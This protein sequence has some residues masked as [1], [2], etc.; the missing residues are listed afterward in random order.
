M[1]EANDYGY[2]CLLLK[3]GTCATDYQNYL[4][5]IKQIKMQGGVFG[6]VSDSARFVKGI[7]SA[8]PK[9]GSNK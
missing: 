5:A 4:A 6:W 9:V 8:F 3:D 1:R 7:R 2:W